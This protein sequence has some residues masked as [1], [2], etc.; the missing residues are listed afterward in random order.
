MEL[1]LAPTTLG[2]GASRSRTIMHQSSNRGVRVRT[3]RSRWSWR[4]RA[5]PISAAFSAFCYFYPRQ[6]HLDRPPAIVARRTAAEGWASAGEGVLA[7][8]RHPSDCGDNVADCN[9]VDGGGE[10][11]SASS[12]GGYAHFGDIAR[13][14][15]ALE[16][17]EALEILERDDPFGTRTFGAELT[18]HE[19]DLGRALVVDE[20]RR[21]FPCPTEGRRITLPDAR[22]E[23][24]ARDFRDG[25]GG[26]FLFFQHIRKV[27]MHSMYSYFLLCLRA[28]LYIHGNVISFV[29]PRTN[30][31]KTRKGRRHQLLQL[32]QSQSSQKRMSTLS[33]HARLGL[34]TPFWQQDFQECRP[35]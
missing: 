17:A 26:T 10:R 33:M 27:C 34:A 14:L 13:D 31:H 35:L 8:L 30:Y 5:I 11:R 12:F 21:L 24:K 6:S 29:N 2:H 19:T 23:K 18:R 1:I 4:R 7:A 20:V 25:K 32:S 28:R 3:A 15:A 22:S 9:D 16:P